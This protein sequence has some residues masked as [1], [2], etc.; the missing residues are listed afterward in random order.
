ME[1][2]SPKL[3][4]D[5]A[6]FIRE[7]MLALVTTHDEQGYISTPLPLL[8]EV[9]QSREI[10]AF[11]GHFALA[12]PHLARVKAQPHVQI[13]FL[14]PHGYISPRL[15]SAKEWGPTWNY[16]FAQFE[17]NVIFEPSRTRE[18][19]VALVDALEGTGAGAWTVDE[20][21]ER[22]ERMAAHVLAFRANVISSSARFKLGQ[23]E[24]PETFCE[25]VASLGN[26][27]LAK[28]MQEQAP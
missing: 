19:I 4:A 16:R 8:A 6:R 3:P 18:A 2:F 7:E 20:M 9:D 11:V 15:V 27:A 25:I 10:C 28:A 24:T 26:S 5:V 12:N 21:G 17:A 1:P 14:G 13:T 22:F 23:D